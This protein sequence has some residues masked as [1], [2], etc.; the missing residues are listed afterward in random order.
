[1]QKMLFFVKKRVFC[2]R[3]PEGPG[4]VPQVLEVFLKERRVSPSGPPRDP[5]GTPRPLRGNFWVIF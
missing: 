3:D 5:S 2:S 4:G 1:M